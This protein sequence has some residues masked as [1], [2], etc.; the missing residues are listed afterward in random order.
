MSSDV[1]RCSLCDNQMPVNSEVCF[2]C[3]TPNPYY[4]L[5]AGQEGATVSADAVG[6][7]SGAVTSQDSS[8]PGEAEGGFD[9]SAL[10]AQPEPQV[11]EAISVSPEPTSGLD[12]SSLFSWSDNSA[13]APAAEEASV[14]EAV[15][16]EPTETIEIAPL[17][18]DAASEALEPPVEQPQLDAA[19]EIAPS[20]DTETAEIDL[21][22]M[23]VEPESPTLDATTGPESE[24]IEAAA[25][26]DTELRVEASTDTEDVITD[27][28]QTVG[29]SE[30]AEVI[31]VPET[32]EPKQ[33]ASS[34]DAA[35]E[36]Q[37][38]DSAST[39]A[40]VMA[41]TFLHPEEPQIQP[42]EAASEAAEPVAS[43]PD[44]TPDVGDIDTPTALEAEEAD[45]GD[46]LTVEETD[47]EMVPVEEL[48]VEE[49]PVTESEAVSLE[50][51]LAEA[52]TVEP[53]EAGG[54]TT[55]DDMVAEEV[56]A[57]AD[58]VVDTSDVVDTTP[59]LS[60]DAVEGVEAVPDVATQSEVEAAHELPEMAQIEEETH[61]TGAPEAESVYHADEAERNSDLA[62]PTPDVAESVQEPEPTH[63]SYAEPQPE[64]TLLT[65]QAGTVQPVQADESLPALVTEH[66]AVA[67]VSATED[68]PTQSASVPT[69][70]LSEPPLYEADEIDA[71][72]LEA[73]TVLTD[74]LL[75]SYD[76]TAPVQAEADHDDDLVYMPEP[77]AADT[78]VDQSDQPIEDTAS[79]DADTLENEP[80]AIAYASETE[81][82][83]APVEAIAEVVPASQDRDVS[84]SLM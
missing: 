49:P 1:V 66:T 35:V 54:T 25:E 41:S 47:A 48:P 34:Q 83:V 7:P 29:F 17:E 80:L 73:A 74:A 55:S 23:E 10:F 46:M 75:Q 39:A 8:A 26:P 24:E 60:Q 64:T 14:E 69:A 56:V 3:G 12:L 77:V 51:Q 81:T 13:P 57:D 9:L 16:A 6:E 62:V 50:A 59:Y 30:R 65:E 53:A 33:L 70:S 68:A 52:E 36:E 2:V 42:L 31:D 4:A 79:P 21:P 82:E 76:E 37:E 44:E 19:S 40:E 43:T 84:P 11:E 18:Q 32:E 58:E 63:V 5:Y 38:P 72:A 78:S 61:L 27:Q 15:S 67:E 22:Q 20:F 28:L 45:A 71:E